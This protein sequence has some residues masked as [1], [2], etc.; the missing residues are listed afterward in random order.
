MQAG[1]GYVQRE[2]ERLGIIPKRGSNEDPF[3]PAKTSAEVRP[4]ASPFQ[5]AR[6]YLR[7]V[8]SAEGCD[9]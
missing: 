7:E 9:L 6:K 5:L 3:V 2:A 1:S 4:A 8:Q